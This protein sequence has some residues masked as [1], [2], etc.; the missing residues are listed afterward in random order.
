MQSIFST[1]T[2]PFL[3]GIYIHVWVLQWNVAGFLRIHVKNRSTRYPFLS[4]KNES[5]TFCVWFVFTD[6]IRTR[7]EWMQKPTYCLHIHMCIP[8]VLQS[9]P[10]NTASWPACDLNP[11]PS[12]NEL[13]TLHLRLYLTYS[14][15]RNKNTRIIFWKHN[16]VSYKKVDNDTK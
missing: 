8:R 9:S 14:L 2:H 5:L 1:P 6:F 7:I 15:E 11:W 4:H 3:S 16:V 12:G 13:K 10:E